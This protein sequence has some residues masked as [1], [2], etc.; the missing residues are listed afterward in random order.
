MAE[1]AA[2]TKSFVPI[3]LAWIHYLSPKWELIIDSP[4]LNLLETL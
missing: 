3:F 1:Y 2:D 4:L